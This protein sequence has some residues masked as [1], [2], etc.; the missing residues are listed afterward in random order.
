[1][2]LAIISIHCIIMIVVTLLNQARASHRLV[3]AW[4]LEIDH[5]CNMFVSACPPLG[6]VITSNVM[7]CS[8]DLIELD[9]QVLLLL[10][11]SYSQYC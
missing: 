7:W 3:H 2:Q 6:L 8:M 10:Y 4:F 1:M 9:K 11:G 5:V